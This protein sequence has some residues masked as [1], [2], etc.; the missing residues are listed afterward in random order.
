VRAIQ[1]GRINLYL[2]YVLATLIVFL[3]LA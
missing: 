2:L 1:S 3:V